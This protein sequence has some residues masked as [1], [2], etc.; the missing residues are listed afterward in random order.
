MSEIDL[1]DS[2]NDTTLNE[3][4]NTTVD[5]NNSWL[6]GGEVDTTL[7]RT[8]NAEDEPDDIS[9]V[10]AAELDNNNISIIEETPEGE[11]EGEADSNESIV[12]TSPEEI[13]E[14]YD[15]PMQFATQQG[16]ESQTPAPT[17]ASSIDESFANDEEDSENCNVVV[18]EGINCV[19]S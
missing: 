5:M 17:R 18:C 13:K 1:L 19:I 4:L 16:D 14:E 8:T 10:L 12:I 15:T 11:G 6:E 3:S 7:E 2:G 9:N